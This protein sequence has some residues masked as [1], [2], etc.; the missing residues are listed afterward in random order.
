MPRRNVIYS[1]AYKNISHQVLEVEQGVV[2]PPGH[3]WSQFLEERFL[4]D[5]QSTLRGYSTQRLIDQ[6][7]IGRGLYIPIF[8]NGDI[9]I[10]SCQTPGVWFRCFATE[11]PPIPGSSAPNLCYTLTRVD[12]SVIQSDWLINYD[13]T[14]P[15][16]IYLA[17]KIDAETMVNMWVDN[18]LRDSIVWEKRPLALQDIEDTPIAFPASITLTFQSLDP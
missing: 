17:M 8:N 3:L 16:S 6:G 13:V 10:E 14:F 4:T 7:Y 5:E 2:I 15:P 18:T 12:S 9:Y 11:F 1:A